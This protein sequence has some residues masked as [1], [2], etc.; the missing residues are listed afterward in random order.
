M[1]S[2]G[3][4]LRDP[5]F[6]QSLL[7]FSQ[8]FTGFQRRHQIILVARHDPQKKFTLVRSARHNGG[9]I[10]HEIQGPRAGIE[11]QAALAFF[12]TLAIFF[13]RTVTTDAI[14]RKHRPNI[15]IK[16]DRGFRRD[17]AASHRSQ[18]AQP[19]PEQPPHGPMV[20]RP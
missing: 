9:P 7:G 3:G 16:I 12:P 15:A 5:F 1:L 10:I 20:S 18:R 4:P 2:V 11:P 14:F 8:L 19:T 13:I 17:H 6:Q